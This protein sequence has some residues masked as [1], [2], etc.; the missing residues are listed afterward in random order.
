[1]FIIILLIKY[2]I[3][4]YNLLWYSITYYYYRLKHH[5]NNTVSL[6]PY[7]IILNIFVFKLIHFRVNNMR[8][9]YLILNIIVCYKCT[10]GTKFA[11]NKEVISSKNVIIILFARAINTVIFNTYSVSSYRQ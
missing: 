2:E 3:M 9:T 10:V 1:M 5:N 7:H 11:H 8:R 4:S 6:R